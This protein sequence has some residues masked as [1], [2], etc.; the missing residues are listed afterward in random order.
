MSIQILT[1]CSSYTDNCCFLADRTVRSTI[2]YKSSS[3]R[4]RVS[5]SNA[6]HFGAQAKIIELRSLYYLWL[7]VGVEG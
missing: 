5:V 6:V 3:Y 7:R 1:Y 2:G 4:C